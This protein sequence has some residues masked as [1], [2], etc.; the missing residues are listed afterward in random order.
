MLWVLVGALVS[1]FVLLRLTRRRR[2]V[3]DVVASEPISP[4]H[5]ELSKKRTGDTK[6]ALDAASELLR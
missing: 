5:L 1:S 4:I 6:A 3:V 2:E